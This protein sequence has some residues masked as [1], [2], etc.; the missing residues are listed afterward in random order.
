[1]H[2]LISS[3]RLLNLIGTKVRRFPREFE[4]RPTNGILQR[5]GATFS[6][7]LT[8]S[9]IAFKDSNDE[10]L[11]AFKPIEDGRQNGLVPFSKRV[12]AR[13]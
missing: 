7:G 12:A 8:L 3:D 11:V 2:L 9:L 5:A 1:M 13:F 10:I 4:K 6:D